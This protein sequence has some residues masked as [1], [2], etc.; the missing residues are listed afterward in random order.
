MVGSNLSVKFSS[1][2]RVI[3]LVKHS[4]SAKLFANLYSVI[5]SSDST[6]PEIHEVESFVPRIYLNFQ[7]PI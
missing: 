6:Y 7:I 3:N 1:E 5:W 4:L 2:Q